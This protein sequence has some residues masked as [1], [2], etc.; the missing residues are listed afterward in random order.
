MRR[1][2]AF[3]FPADFGRPL[4]PSPGDSLRGRDSKMSA[5]QTKTVAIARDSFAR[6]DVVRQRA[7]GECAWCGQPARFRY[8]IHSDGGRRSMQTR[9]FCGRSC[10]RAFNS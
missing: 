5:N 10:E 8:G 1:W 3:D 4:T 2:P 7:H 6:H 9:V